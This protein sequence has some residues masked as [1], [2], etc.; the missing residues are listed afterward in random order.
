[1]F[2]DKRVV[3]GLLAGAAIIGGALASYYL[4]ESE[5]PG[6]IP[7]IGPVKRDASGYIEFEQFL[8]IFKI[9]SASAK[10]QFAAKKKE[11][12]KERRAVP[13]DSETYS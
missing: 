5:S 10:T 11:L 8:E 7:S 12:I 1:M 2:K 4:S 6:E 3:Y 9:S 13:K